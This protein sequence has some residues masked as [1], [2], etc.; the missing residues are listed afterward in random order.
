VCLVGLGVC[1]GATAAAPTPDR[2]AQPVLQPTPLPQLR[3]APTRTKVVR[4]ASDAAAL[5]AALAVAPPRPRTLL[6][7]LVKRSAIGVVIVRR[8]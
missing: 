7:P 3:T 6:V 1:T 8:F 4:P 5:I 2:R